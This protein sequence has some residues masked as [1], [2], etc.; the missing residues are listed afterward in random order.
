MLFPLAYKK[1]PCVEARGG[2]KDPAVQRQPWAITFLLYL[3]KYVF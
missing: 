1:A 3:S 2:M